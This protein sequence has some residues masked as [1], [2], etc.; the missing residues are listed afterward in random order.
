MVLLGFAR[1]LEAGNSEACVFSNA[2]Q[3]AD[4][5]WQHHVSP[6]WIGNMKRSRRVSQRH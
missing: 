5:G 3:I 2:N 1:R 4:R 6:Y